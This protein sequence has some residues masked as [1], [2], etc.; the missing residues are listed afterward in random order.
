MLR[1]TWLRLCVT[2]EIC[3]QELLGRRANRPRSEQL[4]EAATLLAQPAAS[5]SLA[6]SINRQAFPVCR[7]MQRLPEISYKFKRP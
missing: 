4:E 6:G 5:K 7:Q 2:A 3:L 1:S